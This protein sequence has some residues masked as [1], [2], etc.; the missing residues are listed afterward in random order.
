MIVPHD[1]TNKFQSLNISVKKAA[2]SFISEKYNTWITNKVPNQLKRIIS[3]C[4]FKIALQLGIFKPLHTK[5]IV[6]LY[7]HMLQEQENIIS[8][9]KSAWITE[10]IR[11]IRLVLER[12]ENP[13]YA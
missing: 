8:G 12:I 2:K 5:W 4:H 1:L 7:M 3:S 10:A 13:F 9:F 6:K 11:S